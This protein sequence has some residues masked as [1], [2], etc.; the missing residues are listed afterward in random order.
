MKNYSQI[1]D[2]IG[3][4][5]HDVTATSCLQFENSVNKII[6][7]DIKTVNPYAYQN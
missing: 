6:I 2:H 5:R 1:H 7:S 4:D 3:T